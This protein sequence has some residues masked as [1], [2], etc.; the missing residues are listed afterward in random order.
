MLYRRRRRR[1]AKRD[2]S[3]NSTHPNFNPHGLAPDNAGL[4]RAFRGALLRA[5]AELLGLSHV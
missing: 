4:W 3:A 2:L 1:P 5:V